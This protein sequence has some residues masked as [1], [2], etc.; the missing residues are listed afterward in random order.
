MTKRHVGT[1]N[2]YVGIYSKFCATYGVPAPIWTIR[3]ADQ[4]S[5]I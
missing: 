4:L 3:V 2:S 1:Q 5:A